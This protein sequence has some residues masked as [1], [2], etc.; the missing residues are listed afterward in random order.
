[1]ANVLKTATVD[2]I[3]TLIKSGHSDRRLSRLSRLRLAA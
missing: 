1:M 2:D 3:V